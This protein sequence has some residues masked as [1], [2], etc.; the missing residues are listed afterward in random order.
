[1]DQ[2]WRSTIT[3]TCQRAAS[4]NTTTNDAAVTT[5]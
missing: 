3:N 2:S 5:V 1:M 4:A